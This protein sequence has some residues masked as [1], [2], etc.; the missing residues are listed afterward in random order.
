MIS[1]PETASGAE[2]GENY[3]VAMTDMMVGVLLFSF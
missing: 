1:E 3:F 2:E